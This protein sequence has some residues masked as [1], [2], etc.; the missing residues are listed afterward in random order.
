MTSSE[1]V[2]IR[3]ARPDDADAVAKLAHALSVHDNEPTGNFTPEAMRQAVFD[4]PRVRVLVAEIAGR[5]VGYVMFHDSY[6]TAHAARG[7]YLNDIIVEEGA[8]GEGVARR[9]MAAVMREAKKQGDVFVW[10][11][12]KPTNARALAFY[13][14]LGAIQVPTMA[15]VI[16]GDP[17]D[18]LAQEADEP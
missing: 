1:P 5:V 17:F 12:A 9:L 10:W 14:K 13:R 2:A 7:L 8:R 4:D 15:H 11:V 3:P 16:F 6:D 18:T